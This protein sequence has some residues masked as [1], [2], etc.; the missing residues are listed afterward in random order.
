MYID[1]HIM[2]I[3]LKQCKYVY[4]KLNIIYMCV[5][6]HCAERSVLRLCWFYCPVAKKEFPNTW[7]P[8]ETH[9]AQV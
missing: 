7:R 6:I 1:G 8:V 3:Y 4:N 9:I 5:Y 2:P